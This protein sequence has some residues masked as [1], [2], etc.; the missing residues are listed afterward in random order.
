[1]VGGEP[2]PAARKHVATADLFR[3][4][5]GRLGRTPY[6]L[7]SVT[8]EIVDGPMA[9]L[10]LIGEV[11]HAMVQAAGCVARAGA[12]PPACDMDVLDS[13][14]PFADEALSTPAAAKL[15][16][17]C[18]HLEQLPAVLETGV[19]SLYVELADIRQYREAV[20]QAHAAD[21]T[22]Y[23]GHAAD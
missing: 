7:R 19:R 1:M 9:P 15:H 23:A 12:A 13:P 18:R 4:Q 8:A 5:L 22:V 20:I 11:R 17:L 21:G 16:V 14:S 6:E 10:R 3:E 2:L